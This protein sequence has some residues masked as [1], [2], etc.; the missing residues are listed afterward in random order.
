MKIGILGAGFIGRALARLAVAAGDE[1]MIA[2]SRDPSTLT[3]TAVALRCRTGTAE[4]AAQWG[5]VVVV[6]VPFTAIGQLPA[7]AMA[8]KLVLD[9]C[10]HYP[11]RDGADP[12][13]ES[14]AETTGE[15]LAAL[16]PGARVVK[17]FNAILQGDLDTD[18]RPSGARDRRALPIAGDDPVARAET[19]AL[20]DRW[21]FDAVDA[22]AMA[23]S[24]RFE[25][26]MPAYCL[27]FD[28]KGLTDAMA[29]AV[30]GERLADGSWRAARKA[31][32]PADHSDQIRGFTG[33]GRWDIVDS[34]VH[35]GLNPSISEALAAMDALGI[36]TLIADEFWDFDGGAPRPT[37]R[38]GGVLRS[39]SIVGQQAALQYPGRFAWMLRLNREDPMLDPL[40]RLH[41]Q[42]PGCVA[43]RIVLSSR[44]ERE[45]FAAGD[46]DVA[47]RLAVELG[48]AVDFLSAR[49]A[50]LVRGAMERFPGLNL[51][52]DHCGWCRSVE[53]WA[54][55]LTLADLPGV[56][57]KWAHPGRTFQHFPDP[58][59][60]QRDGL[61]QAVAAFG[62]GRV[63]WASDVSADDS[64][65]SWGELLET[66]RAQS[67][68]TDSQRAAVLGETAR[69]VYGLTQEA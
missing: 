49:M 58:G 50:P 35:L 29:G 5:D 6:S 44:K 40:I 43:L 33:R 22:G 32:K 14:M 28:R 2:N 17:A 59:T 64:G 57:L 52:V 25:R 30:R 21:G 54:A 55:T 69:R 15:R 37:A 20:I 16:L 53:E 48:L 13:L 67:G 9:T 47:L 46:W 27:A 31:A 51:V 63:M 36:R 4:E 10:N 3:S 11:Q 24:W 18:A 38:V 68:L 23:E 12:A 7:A 41:A 42:A 26:A 65:A 34:Q 60:A 1:V 45:H 66:V 62:A 61:V 19:A 8:G 56:S 39:L